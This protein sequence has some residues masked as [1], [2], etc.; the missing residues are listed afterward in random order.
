MDARA[1]RAYCLVIKGTQAAQPA[2][3]TTTETE[4]MTTANTT[5][6]FKRVCPGCYE[7]VVQGRIFEIRSMEYHTEGGSTERVWLGWDPGSYDPYMGDYP[8]LAVAKRSLAEW[9]ANAPAVAAHIA[10]NLVD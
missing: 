2:T 5:L 1:R 4:D 8:S 3:I 10:D 7:F 6:R 9:A